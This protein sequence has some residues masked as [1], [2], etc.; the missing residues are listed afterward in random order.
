MIVCAHFEWVDIIDMQ[1][2]YDTQVLP[3]MEECNY[4]NGRV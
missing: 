4:I 3:L 1:I 2:R